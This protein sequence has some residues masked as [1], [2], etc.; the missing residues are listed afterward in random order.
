[1]GASSV[2]LGTQLSHKARSSYPPTFPKALLYLKVQGSWCSAQTKVLEET[3]APGMF[4]DSGGLSFPASLPLLPI[5]PCIL[6][7]P[8]PSLPF[9]VL[10]PHTP[11]F[12][13][14]TQAAS[15]AAGV[16]RQRHSHLSLPKPPLL[17]RR[18]AAQGSTGC[19]GHNPR[20]Y[21]TPG[22]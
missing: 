2:P 15:P 20:P 9:P 14:R 7:I 1:M 8:G 21:Q 5:I 3:C 4:H 18:M 11:P 16:R 22:K 19:A 10:G 6:S 13:L 12:P 17:C